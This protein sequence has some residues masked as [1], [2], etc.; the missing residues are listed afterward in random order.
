MMKVLVDILIA[1][2]V[3]GFLYS[4]FIWKESSNGY[5]PNKDY[6]KEVK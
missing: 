4:M 5:V 1:L 2:I 3:A 6:R